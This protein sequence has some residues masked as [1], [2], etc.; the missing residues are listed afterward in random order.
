MNTAAFHTI[1]D[2]FDKYA[3]ALESFDTKLMA[4]HYSIPCTLLS[5]ESS[6]VFAENSKLEGLFNQGIGFYKQFGIVYAR[7]EVWSKRAWSRNIAKVKV[8]WQYFDAL[9]QPVY[10]C[11]Y[12][13]IIKLDKH[14]QWRIE[15]SVSVNEKE[16]MEEW[17]E[18]IQK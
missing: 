13:Y 4:L 16:R 8:N 6:T 11:D 14:N 10:S 3:L 1:N 7:P 2:F 5:D 15:I 17:L 18:K 9:K 12:H